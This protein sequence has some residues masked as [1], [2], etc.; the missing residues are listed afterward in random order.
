MAIGPDARAKFSRKTL[1]RSLEVQ[2]GWPPS[3]RRLC[4]HYALP[5]KL[6]RELDL[7]GIGAG[8]GKHAYGAVQCP[9]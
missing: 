8:P 2:H 4:Y 3:R 1:T 9:G 6:Q 7:S 5:N